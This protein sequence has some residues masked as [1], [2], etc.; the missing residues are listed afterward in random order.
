M[1]TLFPECLAFTLAEEGGWSDNAA[2]PGGATNKGITLRTFQSFL[3]GATVDDLRIISP[4][5]VSTIY[6]REYWQIMGCD[7]LPGGIDLMI[8]DFGVNA[9]PARSVMYL[10]TVAGVRRDGIDGAITQ[11]AV[12]KMSVSETIAKLNGLQVAHYRALP[13]F[14]RFGDG[15]L[16]RSERRVKRALGLSFQATIPTQAAGSTNAASP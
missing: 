4:A 11:A 14:N 8:F 3:H 2:D 1:N 13:D 10:Q 12:A 7:N 5:M 9:G 16:A 15:W 6:H